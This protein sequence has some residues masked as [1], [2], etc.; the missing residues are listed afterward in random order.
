MQQDVRQWSAM[1]EVIARA[2][3]L[4]AVAATVLMQPEAGKADVAEYRGEGP[5]RPLP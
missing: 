5:R 3:L 1:P 4:M 2:A